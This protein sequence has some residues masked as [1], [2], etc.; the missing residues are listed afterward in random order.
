MIDFIE[1]L[2]YIGGRKMIWSAVRGRL[3]RLKDA[4]KNDNRSWKREKWVSEGNTWGEPADVD[5]R[6]PAH[7]SWL[8]LRGS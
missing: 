6:L 7:P 2:H 1:S 4:G 8:E 5:E 3:W